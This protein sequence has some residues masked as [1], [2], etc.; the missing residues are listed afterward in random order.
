MKTGLAGLR[1][2][3]VEALGISP[4]ADF[5]DLEYAKTPG[6]DS[7]AHMKLISEIE[8]TFDIMLDTED[9]IDMSSFPVAMK[10]VEKHGIALD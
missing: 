4:D 2:A 1:N 6:W 9:V 5:D 8:N 7:V 3:F 10:I